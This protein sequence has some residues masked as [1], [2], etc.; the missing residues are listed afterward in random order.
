ML[1]YKNKLKEQDRKPTKRKM[2]VEQHFDDCGADMSSLVGVARAAEC[3]MDTFYLESDGMG[4]FNDTYEFADL[5]QCFAAIDT[6]ER[7]NIF[8][9]YGRQQ[10]ADVAEVMGGRRSYDQDFATP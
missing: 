6:F 1:K 10:Y 4:D 3:Y 9:F 2:A 5:R 8:P 7:T